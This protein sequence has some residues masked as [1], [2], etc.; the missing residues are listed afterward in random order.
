VLGGFI[1]SIE[2]WERFSD[3]WAAE[4]AAPPAIRLYKNS[5]AMSRTDEF[6]GWSYTDVQNKVSRLVAIIVSHVMYRIHVSINHTEFE[7]FMKFNE[8]EIL[9]DPYYTL[10]LSIIGMVIIALD[11]QDER[12]PVSFIFDEQGSIGFKAL[13][14]ARI[15]NQNVRLH[16]TESEAQLLVG[17]PTFADDKQMMPLQAA[18]LYAGNV[19][20]VYLDNKTLYM[21]LR[22]PMRELKGIPCFSK[23]LN[24]RELSLSA[25]RRLLNSLP[26]TAF[27][28]D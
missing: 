7:K 28:N 23:T 14:M 26:Q 12:H 11:K 15:I 19:R 6:A 24:A 22:Q 17:L 9:T 27:E 20:R 21:P 10:F 8:F 3:A 25:A 4:L 5:Q 2:K 13:E 1:S 16:F 18:D